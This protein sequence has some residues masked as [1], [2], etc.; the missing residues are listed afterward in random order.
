MTNSIVTS[1]ATSDDSQT[2]TPGA[3]CGL[4]NH[5]HNNSGGLVNTTAAAPCACTWSSSKHPSPRLS[6]RVANIAQGEGMADATLVAQHFLQQTAKTLPRSIPTI[7]SPTAIYATTST[8]SPAHSAVMLEVKDE[9]ITYVQ[10][11]WQRYVLLGHV[12]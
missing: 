3:T 9:L 8:T 4:G 7:A 11:Y 10:Y 5:L 2:Q 1:A 6:T 12:K